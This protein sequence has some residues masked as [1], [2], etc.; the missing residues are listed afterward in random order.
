MRLLPELCRFSCYQLFPSAC[1]C[2]QKSKQFLPFLSFI[3]MLGEV[4][5]LNFLSFEIAELVT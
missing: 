3:K 4:L 1:Y 2:F 5:V